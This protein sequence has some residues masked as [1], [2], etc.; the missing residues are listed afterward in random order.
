MF[1]TFCQRWQMLLCTVF[2]TAGGWA[3]FIV[4]LQAAPWLDE[5]PRI[6]IMSAFEPELALLRSELDRPQTYRVNGL[7]FTTGE[8]RGKRA[9]L[10]LSGISMTNAA[11]NTQ[12]ALDRFKISQ[13]VFSGIAGGVN[14]HLN[15]GDVTV[16]QRWGQYLEMVMA[17][18]G[19]D[20][21]FVPPTGKQGIVFPNFGMIFPREVRVRSEQQP[22]IH[23]KFWFDVDPDMLAAAESLEAIQLEACNASGKC[24]RQPPQVV[25]G[26]N[27][28][29]GS[30]FVDN[31]SF[32]QYA[33]DTFQAS[34]LDMESAACAAV[35]YSN[36]VPFIAF[37]AL[38][39]LAGGGKGENEMVTFMDIAAE[40]SARVV[41]AFLE[42]L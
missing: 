36:G 26:G 22:D 17:K 6:A 23:R 18:Q 15:I 38:S 33:Y 29:S 1:I 41:L 35:A 14:P 2:M 13:I 3:L 32:R 9:V 7:E 40:N 8:L 11:M 4:P 20:G 12:L 34:V 42:A 5:Q 19:D 24:L 10:F 25:I 27:G 21:T 37:R 39:D 30:A 16:V 28:V 31:A